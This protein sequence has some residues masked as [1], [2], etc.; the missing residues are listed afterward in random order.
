MTSEE[1]I[2]VMFETI[3]IELENLNKNLKDSDLGK[4]QLS[5]TNLEQRFKDFS[6]KIL[7]L[8]IPVYKPPMAPVHQK[9]DQII[10]Q[11]DQPKSAGT[12]GKIS[13]MT[14]TK[15][16][17][18]KSILSWMIIILFSGSVIVNIYLSN[19]YNRYQN[20][21]MKYMF[22]YQTGKHKILEELDSLWKVDSIRSSYIE[23]I[24]SQ[25]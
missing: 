7:D 15:F 12:F 11:M 9:L 16:S 1:K 25:K 2:E 18:L 4:V 19:N 10:R 13:R 17:R 20:G 5:S 22:L 24:N 23:L 3:L 21:Y 8:K 14:Q 6:D